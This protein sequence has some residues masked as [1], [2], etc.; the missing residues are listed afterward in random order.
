MVVGLLF[1]MYFGGPKEKDG[2]RE[3][4]GLGLCE[5]SVSFG[6]SLFSNCVLSFGVFSFK[7]F[8]ILKGRIG[9]ILLNGFNKGI[10]IRNVLDTCFCV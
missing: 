9:F 7:G 5:V 6:F 4:N 3:L 8:L 10:G 2:T 1:C